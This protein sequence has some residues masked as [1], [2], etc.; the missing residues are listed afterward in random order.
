MQWTRPALALIAL[1]CGGT[2]F[3]QTTTG[4]QGSS[5]ATMAGAKRIRITYENLTTGQSFSPSVFFTHNGDAPPLFKEGE[6]AVFGLMRIAEEGNAG[7]L[8]SAEVVKKIGGPYGTAV[9]A[10]SALPGQK[11]SVE[12]EVDEAHPML[13]GVWMLVM[14]ND[15][16]TG[17]S[18]VD[19]YGLTEPMTMELMAYDAGTENNNEKTPFLIAM[20]GTDRDPEGG[21][22]AM[23]TGIRGD[24]DAPADWK[25]DPAQPVARMTIEPAPM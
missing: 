11:R 5:E 24:A 15:G 23:H 14:T 19:A 10:I 9:E 21:V 25:F 4:S 16:F 8:L 12:I 1:L 6:P 2:A 20:M 13:S 17:V 22:V 7:P 3:A 18:G